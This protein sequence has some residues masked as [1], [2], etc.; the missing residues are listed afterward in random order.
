MTFD[1]PNLFDSAGLVPVMRLARCADPE[2][3]GTWRVKIP[4]PAGC[5][6]ARATTN[7][8]IRITKLAPEPLTLQIHR[9][10]YLSEAPRGP[11]ARG[12]DATPILD[13]LAL[14]DVD[15]IRY[16]FHASRNKS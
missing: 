4:G 5:G 11:P 9:R 16:R 10:W 12:W 2:Q 6:A 15:N 3:L 8:P 13:I 1:E 14:E 7:S